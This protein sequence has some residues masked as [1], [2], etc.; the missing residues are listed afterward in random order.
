[1]RHAL[2][3]LDLFLYSREKHD[4]DNYTLYVRTASLVLRIVGKDSHIL[5]GNSWQFSFKDFVYF[6]T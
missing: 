6:Y 4:C 2:I 1:M 5:Y 3:L